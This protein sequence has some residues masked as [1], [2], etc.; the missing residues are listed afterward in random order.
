MG[1]DHNGALL[2]LWWVVLGPWASQVVCDEASGR[3]ENPAD[4]GILLKIKYPGD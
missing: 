3:T 4:A 1:S 2:S